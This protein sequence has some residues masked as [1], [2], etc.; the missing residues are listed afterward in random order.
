MA[1]T[2]H[3]PCKVF[4]G[5]LLFAL[6]ERVLRGFLNA[7]DL[8]APLEVFMNNSAGSLKPACAFATFASEAEAATVLHKVHGMVYSQISGTTR[9]IHHT[10]PQHTKSWV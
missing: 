10:P 3:D 9:S 5:G 8:P 6:P 4:F 7:H 2:W 1:Q